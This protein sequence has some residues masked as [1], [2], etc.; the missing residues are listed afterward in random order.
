MPNL[1]FL[2]LSKNNFSGNFPPLLQNCSELIFL[3][4]AM[5]EFNGGLPVWIADLVNLRFLQLNHNM[6]Y[7]NIPANITSLVLLQ[8]FSLAS[9]N[10]SGPIPSSFSKL[11]AMT[12]K[13][14]P[15]LDSGLIEG[16]D[17]TPA[18]ILSV[19]MKWQE[20]KFRGTA[21]TDMVSIDLSLNH[22][23]GEIPDEITSLNGLLSLNLSQNHLSQKIPVKIGDM[24]SLESLDL[25]RNNISGEIPTSLSDLTYLSSLDLSYNNLAGRIPTGRQ[26][27]TLYAEDPSLYNGNSRLCGLP[28]QRNCLG[29][30][31]PEHEKKQRS[32]NAHDPV[33]FFYIGLTSGFVVGLW[34]VFCALLFKMAWR[35]AYFRL[36]N[37]LC[38][39]LS[40]FVV[41][42]WGWINTK[43]TAS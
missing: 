2:H 1:A 38:D 24:K 21:V 6:F 11:I 25:S 22:L 34:L 16:S 42:T 19:V 13:H 29:N 32:E 39:K 43:A 4:L 27:D 14:L 26:L 37:K 9:N 41:V 7:G 30:S 17:T 8:Q 18:D 31:P 12:L 20:L 3:D 23:T 28:L 10:I 5:N 36:F 35:H 15:R 40:V 33:I